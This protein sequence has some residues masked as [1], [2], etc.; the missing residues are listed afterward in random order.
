MNPCDIFGHFKLHRKYL[1]DKTAGKCLKCKDGIYD[2]EVLGSKNCPTCGEELKHPKNVMIM[3][4]DTC[5]YG[6]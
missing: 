1:E 2:L 4:C 3:V 6:K 5:G